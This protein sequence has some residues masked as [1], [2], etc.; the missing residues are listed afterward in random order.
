L[1]DILIPWFVTAGRVSSKEK[2][3][4]SEM[5]DKWNMMKKMLLLKM[6]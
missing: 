6:F 4:I 2:Q 5:E 1:Y 3:A